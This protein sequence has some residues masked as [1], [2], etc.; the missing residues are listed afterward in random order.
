M[1]SSPAGNKK[2]RKA[3]WLLVTY[4]V[5]SRYIK[6]SGVCDN[7][8]DHV[9]CFPETLRSFTSSSTDP[10]GPAPKK[11]IDA[12]ILNSP[13]S[14]YR[15]FPRTLI[16]IILYTWFHC[17]RCFVY[18]KTLC[19][20]WWGCQVQVTTHSFLTRTAMDGQIYF[21]IRNVINRSSSPLAAVELEWECS[22]SA[23]S[24]TRC[25]LPL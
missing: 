7:L 10:A 24:S 17:L 13:P 2:S 25:L 21:L 12:Q 22:T 23:K 1:K 11:S 18:L 15:N 16:I 8:C 3:L 9:L 5:V 6:N 20:W 19:S 14:T 4:Y